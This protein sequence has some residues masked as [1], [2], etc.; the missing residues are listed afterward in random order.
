MTVLVIATRNKGKIAEIDRILKFEEDSSNP[1]EVKSVADFDID[2]VDETGSTFE[3]NALLKAL[4]VARATGLPALADDSGLAVDA[5]GGA[6]GIYSARYSGVHGD[7]GAN[8]EKLLLELADHSGDRSARFVAVIALAKPDGSHILAR[9][10]LLGNIAQ[11]QRGENGFGY[12]PIFIPTGSN[13]TL[14]E[15]LPE[16]KD[17]ISHR[18]RALAEIAPKVPSFISNRE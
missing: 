13:R 5:L 17:S 2:D 9:G 10:E 16:E 4:T 11:S 15:F 1:I 14:G 8:I 7:D 12:D 3:E 18:A 6:P